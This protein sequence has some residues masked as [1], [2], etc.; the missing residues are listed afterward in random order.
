[1]TN[2]F[3]LKKIQR[4]KKVNKQQENMKILFVGL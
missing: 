1:M 2:L 3:G 4:N